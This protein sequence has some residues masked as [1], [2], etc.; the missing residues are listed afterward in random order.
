MMTEQDRSK[1]FWLL[2]KYS[3]YTAWK[4]LGDAYFAFSDAYYTAHKMRIVRDIHAPDRKEMDEWM[5]GHLKEVLDGR[6]CFEQ[7]LPRLK[8]GDRSVW[9]RNSR[10]A[11]AVGGNKIY[12]IGQIMNEREFVLDW[13]KNKSDVQL[14]LSV[15]DEKNKGLGSVTERLPERGRATWGEKSVFDP[16][17]GPFNFPLQLPE[18]PH[19]TNIVVATGEEVP[20][21]GIYEPEWGPLPN[22]P[23]PGLL[24]KI[25]T[26][27]GNKPSL[28]D[29][30]DDDGLATVR[31]RDIGC[32]N[33][34]LSCTQ[35]PLYQD[36]EL[37]PAIPVHWRLIWKDTRYLDGVIPDDEAEYLAPVV[38][39]LATRLRC[40]AG[41]PCPREGWW[42]TPAGGDRQ[43][44]M[45]GQVMPEIE[46]DYGQTIWQWDQQQT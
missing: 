34:L 46:S 28:M 13:M 44:F 26:L 31:H 10:G 42:F 22:V 43:H 37:D 36:G 12:F 25:K 15:L 29:D 3:S 5:A 24:D 45:L 40:K 14:A 9:R 8:Q 1:V 23:N 17:Y 39:D 33:Y 7:G 38:A 11:L 18:V 41:Q 16:F 6:I 21:D 4:A 30:V 27:L 32:M 2:K 35:A 19:P 20:F